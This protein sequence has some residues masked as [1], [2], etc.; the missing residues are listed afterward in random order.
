MRIV[1]EVDGR[2][3]G[4]RLAC[5]E[6]RTLAQA[7][8]AECPFAE[9]NVLRI[10]AG[11]DTA[12]LQGVCACNRQNDLS[13]LR[14]LDMNG[15]DCFV[16]LLKIKDEVVVPVECKEIVV[17]ILFDQRAL[18]R[19]KTFF[20]IA[21]DIETVAAL[22]HRERERLADEH[23]AAE[24]Q[25]SVMIERTVRRERGIVPGTERDGE[26]V[27]RFGQHLRG[28]ELELRFVPFIEA[29]SIALHRD[30][31]EV[32]AEMSIN[33]REQ[34]PH[35]VVHW[36]QTVGAL[37]EQECGVE[38]TVSREI[39]RREDVK[40]C[41]VRALLLVGAQAREVFVVIGTAFHACGK[42]VE[43]RKRAVVVLPKNIEIVLH[44]RVLSRRDAEGKVIGAA[45]HLPSRKSGA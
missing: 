36:A 30:G 39:P 9:E 3:D 22:R 5:G 42:I 21:S 38:S 23:V 11:L 25:F 28:G 34:L 31:G 32:S 24:R 35:L 20:C 26:T 16:C 33:F 8:I 1:P 2:A 19:E 14:H 29:V 17:T 27:Q 15:I 41:R 13:P 7:I 10:R 12:L 45:W 40:M 37:G 18:F 43:Q 44:G 6:R 4:E